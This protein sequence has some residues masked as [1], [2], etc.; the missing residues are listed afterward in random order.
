MTGNTT[1]LITIYNGSVKR[2]QLT[3]TTPA[4]MPAADY[5]VTL[6]ADVTEI[7][8]DLIDEI[9]GQAK[10]AAGSETNYSATIGIKADAT[11]DFGSVVI[12]EGMSVTF[13]G[14]AGGE[15]PTSSLRRHWALMAATHSS[16]SRT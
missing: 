4:P 9:A 12:P 10:A 16:S 11:L 1:Y 3:I 14:I 13:F 5:K 6:G 7:N 15:A 8:Q 2:G